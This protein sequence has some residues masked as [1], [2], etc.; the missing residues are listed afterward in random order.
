MKEKEKEKLIKCLLGINKMGEEKG[1]NPAA[2][3]RLIVKL[4]G[5]WKTDMAN[6]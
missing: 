1:E 2:W 4:K 6:K 5:I 3:E